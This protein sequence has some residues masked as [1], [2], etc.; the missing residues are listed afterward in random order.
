MQE[1]NS[2]RRKR[3]WGRLE[4]RVT[5]WK[6]CHEQ[7]RRDGTEPEAA[8][9]FFQA[10]VDPERQ[11][12]SEELLDVQERCL[13]LCLAAHW[14]SQVSPVPLGQLE[15]LEKK[16][17]LLRV[18]C[19][20]LAADVEEASVF[21]PP[22][23]APGTSAYAALM[24]DLSM[25]KL[26]CLKADAWLRLDGLPGP[27]EPA[28]AEPPLSPEEGRVLAAL[29]GQSLDEGSVHEASRACRY[30][31]L[32]HQDVWLVLRCRG[33][34]AGDLEP[35][36]APEAPPTTSITPCK[37]RRA[38]R[39]GFGSAALR[40]CPLSAASSASSLLSSSMLAVPDDGVAAQLQRLV[41]RCCHGNGYCKRVLGLYQLSKVS[42]RVRAPTPPL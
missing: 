3:Q 34:A 13:L 22:P 16:L 21:R 19:H 14:L 7:L 40:D 42:K 30:F 36:E 38:P 41:D 11:P 1:A 35:E 23:A 33:L 18:R 15:S 24:T 20:S 10:Q 4:T 2:Q 39:E 25:S 29:I 37:R 26:A 12:A 5:F 6:K 8:R 27:C 31:S 32:Y 17:W 28:G 9:R